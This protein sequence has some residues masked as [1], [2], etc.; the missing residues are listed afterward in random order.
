MGISEAASRAP[1]PDDIATAVLSASSTALVWSGR[2][3]NIKIEEG[4]RTHAAAAAS[5]RY[6]ASMLAECPNLVRMTAIAPVVAATR[7]IMIVF[8]ENI[9][10]CIG[11]ALNLSSPKVPQERA[12]ENLK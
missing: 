5:L 7:V 8:A 11:E 12:G 2:I 3:E 1:G 4:P 6:P 9:A 10:V